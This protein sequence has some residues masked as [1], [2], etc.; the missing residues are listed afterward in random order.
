MTEAADHDALPTA[1]YGGPSTTGTDKPDGNA[2]LFLDAF[3]DHVKNGVNY[4]SGKT[5]TRLD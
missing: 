4:H 5:G 1:Y 3:L 2:A